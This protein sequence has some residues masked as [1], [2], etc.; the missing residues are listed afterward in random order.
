MITF[1]EPE[2]PL[3]EER[4]ANFEKELGTS[5]PD[6]YRRFLLRTN[7]GLVSSDTNVVDLDGAP[8]S[9]TDVHVF[10]GIGGSV[11]SSELSW[12]RSTFSERI[13]DELLPIADDSGGCVFCLSLKGP[14]RGAVLFCDLQSVAFDYEATPK[15]YPVA[16]DFEAFLTKIRPLSEED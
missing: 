3:T 2:P 7:G 5:L 1:R 15:F 8:W 11:E 13:P 9:S 14:D 4:V 6:Q 10:F 16:P 12:N